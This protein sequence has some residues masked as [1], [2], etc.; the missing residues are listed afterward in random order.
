MIDRTPSAS[1]AAV[2]AGTH[3]LLAD[4]ARLAILVTLAA[5]PE[6]VDFT[7]LLGSLGLTRGNFATH[8]RRLEDARLLTVAKAF[9]GRRPRTT[10]AVTAEGRA[11]VRGYLEAVGSLLQ[12]LAP[13]APAGAPP[14][15]RG[16][17]T[18]G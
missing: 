16:R 12:T 10:Y 9:V 1:P 7:T 18:E 15:R 8:A 5:A 17:L 13:P 11:A 2:L 4:R 3:P 6:P 14:V